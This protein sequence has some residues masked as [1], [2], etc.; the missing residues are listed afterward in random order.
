MVITNEMVR[1][2]IAQVNSEVRYQRGIST[3]ITSALE[4]PGTV[5][6]T[7]QKIVKIK[8]E[9]MI[10]EKGSQARL[11]MPMPCCY[12]KCTAKPDSN[13]VMTLS[14][15]LE[16]LFINDG[17]NIYC[18]GVSGATDE[19]EV[20]FHVGSNEFRMNKTFTNLNTTHF[21]RNGIEIETQK[22]EDDNS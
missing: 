19:F 15:P 1:K 2:K 8:G 4:E 5:Q 3:P 7:T 6:L 22:K 14:K 20:R 12:W 17:S 16:G 18:L 9:I 10:T 21:V 13:G 11:F